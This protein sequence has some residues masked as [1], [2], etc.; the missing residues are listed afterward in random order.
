MA[1]PNRSHCSN[2]GFARGPGPDQQEVCSN[3]QTVGQRNNVLDSKQFD[4][5][6]D[7]W[8]SFFSDFLTNLVIC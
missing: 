3:L 8:V 4:E 1:S 5:F 7:G 2:H 6:T